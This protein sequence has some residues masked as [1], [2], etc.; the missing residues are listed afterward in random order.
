MRELHAGSSVMASSSQQQQA[1]ASSSKQQQAA[2]SSSKQQQA[3]SSKQ[4]MLATQ[5]GCGRVQPLG[6]FTL[7]VEGAAQVEYETV[8]V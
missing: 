2:A 8:I 6:V 3:A 5:E 1:A 7:G 4:L